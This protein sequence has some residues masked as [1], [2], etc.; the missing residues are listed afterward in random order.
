MALNGTLPTEFFPFKGD[1]AN[2]IKKKQTRK[3]EGLGILPSARSN[4]DGPENESKL[5]L[6]V[7]GGLSYQEITAIKEWERSMIVRKKWTKERIILGSV[8]FHGE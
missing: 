2:L 7:L 6:V 8:P 5:I 1:S 4:S 3:S